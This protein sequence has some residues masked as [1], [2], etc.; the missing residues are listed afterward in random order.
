MWWYL[1]VFLITALLISHAIKKD[2]ADVTVLF[3]G[4]I[5]FP[6]VRSSEG[7]SDSRE[8]RY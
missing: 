1:P 8:V 7:G 4:R 6:F 3:S 2:R 5:H